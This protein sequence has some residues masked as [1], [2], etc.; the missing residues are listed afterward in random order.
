M[1]MKIKNR[2]HRYDINGL[3]FRH[4]HRY[5]KYKKWLSM[6]V[7]LCTK[8]YLSNIWSSI[9]KTLRLSWK[10]ALLIKKRVFWRISANGG[11]WR[12]DRSEISPF[13]K[14]L[15]SAG[16]H[17]FKVN[18]RYTR[19]MCEICSKLATKTPERRH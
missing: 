11:F 2:P 13:S 14:S 3:R 7:L 4:G 1:K 18:Y 16:I 12:A 17:L 19:T 10:K 9:H 6:M 8:Q 5:S 15:W